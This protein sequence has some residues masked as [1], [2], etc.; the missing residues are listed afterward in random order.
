[1][2]VPTDQRRITGR[3][4]DGCSARAS[5]STERRSERKARTAARRLSVPEFNAVHGHRSPAR[6]P[7][8]AL[9]RANDV[10]CDPSA[11][12]RP[13][14]RARQR[15]SSGPS[16]DPYDIRTRKN[17]GYELISSVAIIAVVEK[18]PAVRRDKL[19]VTKCG[20]GKTSWVS[21]K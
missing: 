12:E 1:M 7:R 11:I 16:Q 10:V 13:G 15:C 9:K 6:R 21:T 14:L 4:H 17:P 19:A 5:C 8:L 20:G 2:R 18:A 3:D